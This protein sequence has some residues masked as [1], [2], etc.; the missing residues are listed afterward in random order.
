[1]LSLLSAIPSVLLLNAASN[2]SY[3]PIT[4]AGSGGYSGLMNNSYG[5]Y[6]E[7]FNACADPQCASPDPP[8][9]QGC[10][11][12]VQASIAS[13]LQ[14]GG[15]RV[16]N[17]DSYHNQKAVGSAMRASGVAR[18]ELFFTTKVG[19][20]LP[21]GYAEARAQFATTLNV[22]GLGYADL[23]LIHWPVCVAEGCEV[24][25]EA[26]CDYKGAGYDEKECRLATWRGLV[27]IWKEGGARAIGVSNYNATHLQEIV[28]AGLP[29]PAVNQCPFNVWHSGDAQKGGLMEVEARLGVRHNGYSPFGV[30]DRRTYPAPFPR[31]MLE[32]EQVVAIAKAHGR[33]P[34]EIALAWQW[35]LGVVVNP[36]SQNA[37]HMVENLGYCEWEGGGRVVA[38][39]C[40]LSHTRTHTTLPQCR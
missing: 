37:A 22:T 31:T 4:G 36:R 27:S 13:W 21:M 23:L 26:S 20:Y 10:G 1:M 19:A 35:Q 16:D 11:E 39:I 6:P 38:G 30:P 29:L 8:G 25:Q 15:R 5:S 2:T 24:T 40:S 18:E 7:C 34:A 12:Y 3:M 28:E 32:D 14:L 9:F 17:S 33:A